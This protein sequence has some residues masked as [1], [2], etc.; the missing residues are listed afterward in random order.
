M[1]IRLVKPDEWDRLG[2][3]FEA[4][5]GHLPDPQRATAAVAIDDDGLAGFWT[6]QQ[7]L[8]AGPL[9]IRE[10]KR[11]TRLWRPLNRELVKAL[12]QMPGNGFYSFADGA[13][14]EHVFAQLGYTDMNYRVWKKEV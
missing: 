1:D 11:G 13:R 9:W 10:D 8:H 5:G 4:E 7:V 2:P 6:L 14:M 12:E 3:I